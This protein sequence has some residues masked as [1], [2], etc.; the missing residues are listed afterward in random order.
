MALRLERYAWIALALYVVLIGGGAYASQVFALRMLTHALFTAV[1]LI[2]L[3]LRLR[4]GRGLPHTP[5][6]FPLMALGGAWLLSSALGPDP[7]LA[8][9]RTWPLLNAV[10]LYWMMAARIQAG[11]GRVI[12]EGWLLAAT[13]VL[14][15]EMVELGAW[16]AGWAAVRPLP[17]VMPPRLAWALN[18]SNWLA[19]FAAPMAVLCIGWALTKLRGERLALLFLGS[20]LAVVVLLTRVRGGLLALAA[21]VLVLLSAGLSLFWFNRVL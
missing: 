18:S 4:S 11:R 7:R 12:L 15:I 5:L 20:G 1:A 9:E 13:A 17:L 21:A 6:T 3:G 19:G 16:Y 2:W 8:F 14:M 10:L